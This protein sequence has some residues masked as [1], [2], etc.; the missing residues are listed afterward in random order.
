MAASLLSIPAVAEDGFDKLLPAVWAGVPNLDLR[1]RYEQV[2][3]DPVYGLGVTHNEAEAITARLRLG[4]TTSAWNQLDAQVELE[5]LS[6][7]GPEHFQSTRNFQSE[8]PV[9]PDPKGAELNQAWL[10]YRGLP[11]TT[12][13]LGR[14]RLIYD[15]SRFIGNVGWRQNEQTYDGLSMTGT[16][17]AKTRFNYAYLDKVNAFRSYRVEPASAF[18]SCTKAFDCS[19]DLDIKAHLFNLAI[20]PLSKADWL[21]LT[22]YAYLLDFA[23]DTPV[24]RDTQTFGLRAIG[25]V[26]YRVFAFHYAV[27]YA[28]QQDYA[29][30]PS[31]VDARYRLLELGGTC[32]NL[33]AKLGYQVLGGNGVYGLQT[34]LATVHAQTG[35]A[36]AFPVTSV[37]GLEHRYLEARYHFQKIGLTTVYHR[38]E[39]D[40]GALDYGSEIDLQAIYTVSRQLEV[41][42]KMARYGGSS[43]API[44][45]LRSDTDKAW[46]WVEYKL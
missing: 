16:W 35:W 5:S 34:P 20:T 15:N 40:E 3:L 19:N 1:L 17:L 31:T 10:R 41:G 2:A 7:L 29:D 25:A 28:D 38:F 4:Y 8:Y 22:P 21:T 6:N 30:S 43:E 9:I 46:A 37:L 39:T 27:E 12:F 14:Q 44:A 24:R 23:L 18:S 33:F 32:K 11:G 42:I 36:D 13:K 45:N 26:P